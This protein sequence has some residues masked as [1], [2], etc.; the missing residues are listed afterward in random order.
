MIPRTFQEN[1]ARLEAVLAPLV[2]R[3]AGRVVFLVDGDRTLTPAD[4]SRAFLSLAGFDPMIVKRC[5]QAHGYCFESFRFHA[6]VH[7]AL[8][9]EAFA[10]HTPAVAR[11]TVPFA[12]AMEFLRAASL[13]GDAFVVSAGIPRIW[14]HF[15]DSH[16]LREVG[17]IG[18]IDPELPFVFGREEKGYVAA[19]FRSR[20][21]R[22][23]AVGDSEVDADML[24][25][26]HHAVVVTNHKHNADLL[27]HLAGHPSAGQVV[28]LGV[29]LPGLPVL[30]FAEL[31]R[32]ADRPFLSPE[33]SPCP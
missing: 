21:E 18:G 2:E 19:R 3:A 29:P 28:T 32:L 30:T 1:L 20:A 9:E 11:D 8:G 7:V 5:F 33:A 17:V 4:T 6:E 14:R 31:A 10:L 25:H 22:V 27:P 12:G 13:R 23:V 24:G 16:G 15:L 26:A